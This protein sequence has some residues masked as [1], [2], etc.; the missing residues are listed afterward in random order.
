MDKINPVS[1]KSVSLEPSHIL[2]ETKIAVGTTYVTRLDNELSL[3]IW[4]EGVADGNSIKGCVV[5]RKTNQYGPVVILFNASIRVGQITAKKLPN[6]E[7]VLCYATLEFAHA[8]WKIH[9]MRGNIIS[10]EPQLIEQFIPTKDSFSSIFDVVLEWP[11]NYIHV[12]YINHLKGLIHEW[13]SIIQQIEQGG[14]N[15]LSTKNINSLKMSSYPGCNSIHIRWVDITTHQLYG[16]TITCSEDETLCQPQQ[17]K[18][19]DQQT[20][21]DVKIFVSASCKP[22]T[23]WFKTRANEDKECN[24]SLCIN[25]PQC[26]GQ[27][28]VNVESLVSFES[29]QGMGI[30]DCV[31]IAIYLNDKNDSGG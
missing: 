22:Y 18:I 13:K 20:V 24:L 6:K 3:I 26:Y 4:L 5:N 14:I 15:I 29:L 19:M 30:N 27:Q 10:L 23:A 31:F 7:F 1:V 2:S 28:T 12:L 8:K 21:F 25:G 17:V 11:Y 16:V 9:F